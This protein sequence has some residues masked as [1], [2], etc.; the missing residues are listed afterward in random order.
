M[1]LLLAAALALAVGLTAAKAFDAKDEL[2]K[3]QGSWARAAATTN[4]KEATEAELKGVVLTLK[5]DEYT[6]K[7]GDQ[8]RKGTF[9]VDPSKTPK[10]L[11]IIAAE[12]PNKGKTLPAIYELDGDTLRYCVAQ[13]DKPRPTEFSAKADSGLSLYVYKRQK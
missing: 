8:V 7:I 9:K 1:R 5:G 13:P 12:G 6:L 10:Q 2:E 4:G 11:D 3:F